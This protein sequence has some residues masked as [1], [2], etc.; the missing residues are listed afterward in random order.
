MNQ[1]NKAVLP[2]A[3]A[4]VVSSAAFSDDA[5]NFGGYARLGTGFSDL[6]VDGNQIDGLNLVS[7]QSIIQTAGSP[8]KV[9][10]RLGNENFG[11]EFS[12]NKNFVSGGTEWNVE[13]ALEDY[14]STLDNID[15]NR[16]YTTAK[17]L[18]PYQRNAKVWAGRFPTTRGHTDLNDYIWM[19]NVGTGAGITELDYGAF[20]LDVAYLSGDADG[21]KGAD[22]DRKAVISRL[23]NIKFIETGWLDVQ[24][25]YG[26]SS[27][28]DQRQTAQVAVNYH[29][30]HPLGWTE[31]SARYGYNTRESLLWGFGVNY[32]AST[33]SEQ[34]DTQAILALVEGEFSFIEQ[35]NI[36][37][38]VQFELDDTNA[39]GTENKWAQAVIRPTYQWNNALSTSVELGYDQVEFGDFGTNSSWK[40]TVAQN[41]AFGPGT[42]A[43]PII[44]TFVTYGELNTNVP[45]NHASPLGNVSALSGGVMFEAW[46]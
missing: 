14:S 43:R 29:Q 27:R 28:D 15:I 16:A 5:F 35:L 34:P 42:G 44:R 40:A 23:H 10:G 37:Y 17:G 46:W 25:G 41:L 6:D 9:A 2:V 22:G 20:K 31:L 45:N 8:Y 30:N 4:L 7:G 3:V 33:S 13:I 19:T 11:Y 36:A 32:G 26:F 38:L 1:I 12:L 21:S 18:I 39:A 24:L